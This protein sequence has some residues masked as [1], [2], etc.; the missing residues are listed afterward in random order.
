LKFAELLVK[1]QCGLRVIKLRTSADT[2]DH[3]QQQTKLAEI[4]SSL[5]TH[6]VTLHTEFSSSLHDREIRCVT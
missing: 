2:T 1:S 3:Q 6:H 4:G 5:A